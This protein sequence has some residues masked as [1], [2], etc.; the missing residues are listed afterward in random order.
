MASFIPATLFAEEPEKKED[1][2]SKQMKKRKT[3][4]F[5]VVLVVVFIGTMW[6]GN[7]VVD[8]VSHA[9]VVAFMGARIF[10]KYL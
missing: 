4:A 2:E 10:L 9:A 7:P 6:E 8:K 5:G 1:Q 3:R